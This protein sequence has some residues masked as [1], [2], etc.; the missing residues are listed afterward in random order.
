MTLTLLQKGFASS[1]Q[2]L[3]RF[4]FQK[5]GIIVG[6]VMDPPSAKLANW[7]VGNTDSAALIEYSF[8]GPSVLFTEDT[9]FALTGAECHPSLDGREIGTG[10]PC[11]ARQ[12]QILTVGGLVSGS[13]GYLAVAG[14]IDTPEWFGSRSTYERA[15]QGGFKGRLLQDQD[16]IPVGKPSEFAM[17]IL[18]EM[19]QSGETM[20]KWFFSFHRSYR[21]T[22]II[23]I[24]PDMLWKRFSEKSRHAFLTTDYQ[25]TTSSDRMG[26][27]LEGESLELD[28]PLELYS[29]AVTNG[30]IQVPR[31]GQPII[32]LTD[33]QSTGGYPRIAQ[34]AS[35]DLP[36]LA[37]L[38]P[39]SKL[40]FHSISVEEAEMLFVNSWKDFDLLRKRVHAQLA[41]TVC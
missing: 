32:L 40:R 25:V 18:E 5:Y 13:R 11:F 33:H 24:I 20:S 10:R 4:G 28:Q 6:G 3:G 29:E 17:R 7:L 23:R 9:L 35:V 21:G 41:S 8:M 31:S 36:M 19:S 27:R 12:G 34:V 22:K 16:Q 26:Y 1:I 39:S 37:Q 15:R 2:D 14:G 38:G 30:S